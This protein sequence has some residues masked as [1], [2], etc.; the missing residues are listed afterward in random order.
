MVVRLPLLLLPL[1]PTLARSPALPTLL[2]A[3]PPHWFAS[4]RRE[5]LREEVKGGMGGRLGAGGAAASDWE[6]RGPQGI[7]GLQIASES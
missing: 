1:P 3:R 5:G 4:S 6:F 2:R 7:W